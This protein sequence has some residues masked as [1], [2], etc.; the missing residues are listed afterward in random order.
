M[1]MS[2][3]LLERTLF[4]GGNFSMSLMSPLCD[5]GLKSD[6]WTLRINELVSP[7]VWQAVASTLHAA[8][9]SVKT[10]MTRKNARH[11][12]KSAHSPI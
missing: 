7:V 3:E 11:G 12:I 4:I 2:D 6:F 10:L 1:G 9:S 5:E 8:M